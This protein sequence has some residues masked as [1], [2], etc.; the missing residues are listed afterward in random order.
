M[1]LDSV[2]CLLQNYF[3]N[4]HTKGVVPDWRE[5]YLTCLKVRVKV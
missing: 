1:E 4:K 2:C 3:A 5:K